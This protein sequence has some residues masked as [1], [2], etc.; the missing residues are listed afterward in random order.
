MRATPTILRAAAHAPQCR[1][2]CL[3]LLAA[4]A[5]CGQTQR[6]NATARAEPATAVAPVSDRL[7][8]DFGGQPGIERLID[9]LLDNIARDDR[10]FPIFREA[11][12]DRLRSKLI[13]KFCSLTGGPCEYTGAS[14]I[15]A[16]SGLNITEAQFN[17]LVEDL[18][19]AMEAQNVP[20]SAQN[21]LL[22]ILAPMRPQVIHR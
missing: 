2:L 6:E 13:E 3:P 14:I 21:R 20:V 19:D 5:A 22:A 11:N 12:I 18:I 10:I 9:G 8:R 17:A 7:Y 16:H 1:W 15:E 4:L